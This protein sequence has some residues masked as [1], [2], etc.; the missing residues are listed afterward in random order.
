[1]QRW[2]TWARIRAVSEET[3]TPSEAYLVLVTWPNGTEGLLFPRPGNVPIAVTPEMGEEDM[4]TAIADL[5][6]YM[7]AEHK[8]EGAITIRLIKFQRGPVLKEFRWN[9]L[10]YPQGQWT[11]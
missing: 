9:P 2:A 3:P 8:I 7:S 1:M 6:G 4:K 11:K 5:L 10:L